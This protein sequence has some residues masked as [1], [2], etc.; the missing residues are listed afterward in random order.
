VSRTGTTTRDRGSRRTATSRTGARRAGPVTPLPDRRARS[1]AGRRRRPVQVA[2][3]LLALGLLAWVLWGSP[4][5]A[6]HT[7]RVDGVTTL[8]VDQVR[9]TAGIAQGTPL[10][11]VDVT[12]ARQRVAQLPQVDS[13][14]VSRG[15]PTTVV[16]TVVER[17]PVAVVGLPGNR[18]LVDAHGVLFDTVTGD[19]PAGVVPLDVADPGPDDASTRAALGALVSLPRDVRKQVTAASATSAEDV[20]LTLRGGTVVRWGS[21]D[22]TPAKAAALAAVLAQIE[23]DALDP[24]DTIDVSTPDAV[25]LR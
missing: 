25:V 18:S 10:L 22:D 8:S 17:T 24:A 3:A 6:V 11:R 15:W 12:A 14:E 4:L 9:E 23:A 16:I 2:T 7:V 1:A 13:V 5:L 19:A 21:A 20:S